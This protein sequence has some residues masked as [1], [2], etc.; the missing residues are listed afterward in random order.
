MI[1][2]DTLNYERKEQ[3]TYI[4]QRSSNTLL[5]FKNILTPLNKFFKEN[6]FSK[7]LLH[8]ISR[9]MFTLSKVI[10]EVSMKAPSF[11]M[12]FYGQYTEE[13]Q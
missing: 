8:M 2:P 7:K 3:W 11:K 1:A 6:N 4:W 9:D 5:D 12:F 13:C 10:L